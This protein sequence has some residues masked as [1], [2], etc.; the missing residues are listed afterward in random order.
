MSRPDP[1]TRAKGR[2]FFELSPV[3]MCLTGF[4]DG[5]V[6]DVNEAFLRLHGHARDEVIGRH[7][8]ELGLWID[9]SRR[10]EAIAR[11]RRG[12]PVRDFTARLRVKGGEE[13]VCV[14]SPWSSAWSSCTAARYRPPARART[15]AASSSCACRLWPPTAPLAA[16]G[17]GSAPSRRHHDAC[18][19]WRG[20]D[21]RESLRL[22]L[23]EAGHVV[24]TAEDGA[25]GLAKLA[26]FQPDVALIDIGL[27][28]LDGYA[29]AR[30]DPA[31]LHDLLA[32]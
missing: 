25:T 15:A 24:E 23:E 30:Q 13:R 17:M 16:T 3:I 6:R 8:L 10:D 9:S 2:A 5:R 4:G 7:V 14:A 12:E 19:S 21:A 18:S 11:L 26:T 1:D 20:A 22:L 28:G 29:L 27:P 31:A 32:R